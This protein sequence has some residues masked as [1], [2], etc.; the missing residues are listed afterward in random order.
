MLHLPG[1]MSAAEVGEIRQRAARAAWMESRTS[2]AETRDKRHEQVDDASDDGRAISALAMQALSRSGLFA[3]AA[4]PAR[5]TPPVLTRHAPGIGHGPQ[6]DAAL[7]GGREA[8]RTDLS[9]TLFVSDPTTYDGGELVVDGSQGR[10]SAKLPAGDLVLY[11]S[12]QLHTVMP[13]V[14]GVRLGCV[15]W[16][17][18]LV[19]DH[20]QRAL[21]FDLAQCMASGDAGGV[22]VDV[23]RLTGVYH[24]LV[25]MWVAP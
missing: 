6:V 23:L 18:S 7:I 10:Q 21:L 19:Q 20:A 2:A 3:Q 24:R 1:V 12:T 14:R 8:L 22:R 16:V 9:G 25:Q 13:V 15:F 17:Q 4:F 11:P 5:I